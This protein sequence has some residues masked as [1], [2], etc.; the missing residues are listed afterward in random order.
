MGKV[1]L[2]I[3]GIN[4]GAREG[5]TVLEVS[6]DAGIYIPNLCADPDLEPYGGCRLC[7]VEIEGIE[8]YYGFLHDPRG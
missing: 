5:A 3:D 1:S 7:L 6:R 4:V 8:D 2:T